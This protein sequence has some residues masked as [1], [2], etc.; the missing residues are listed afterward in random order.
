MKSRT[1]FG[2]KLQ[3]LHKGY[4]YGVFKVSCRI[5]DMINP[6]FDPHWH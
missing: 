6:V 3:L 1:V 2:V 5:R 4:L